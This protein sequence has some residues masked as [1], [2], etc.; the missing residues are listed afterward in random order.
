MMKIMLTGANG[1]LASNLL[2]HLKKIKCELLLI[3]K[4]K[5]TNIIKN[6]KYKFKKIDISKKDQ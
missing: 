3:D 6:R 2:N 1:F 4:K 5:N